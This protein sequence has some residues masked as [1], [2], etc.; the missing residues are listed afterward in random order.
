M[1]QYQAKILELAKETNIARI[2]LAEIGRRIGDPEPISAQLVQHHIHKLVKRGFI[3]IDRR[4]GEFKLLTGTKTDSM[5]KIPLVGAANC[6]KADRIADDKIEGF[7]SV[8]PKLLNLDENKSYFAIKAVGNSMNQAKI[9]T[10]GGKLVGIRN[11]DI[12][13]AEKTLPDFDSKPYVV[14]VADGLA[15]IKKL[16]KGEAAL[17]LQSESSEPHMPI[18][19][20]PTE[21]NLVAGKVV[22]VVQAF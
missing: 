22:G 10:F 6:G 8:S 2:S 5:F 4:A 13:I 3:T 12:V 16:V 1:N 9:P 18:Y 7:V 11:N 20:D 21:T 19:I 15:N 14:F 17:E